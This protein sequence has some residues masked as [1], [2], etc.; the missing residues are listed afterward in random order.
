MKFAQRLLYLKTL[1]KRSK[2]QKKFKGK[3]CRELN[4]VKQNLLGDILI[5]NS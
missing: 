5:F 4:S 2:L 1:G 3:S